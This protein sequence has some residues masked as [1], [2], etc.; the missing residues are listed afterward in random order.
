MMV[1]FEGTVKRVG[2][3]KNFAS[4]FAKTPVYISVQTGRDRTQTFECWVWRRDESLLTDTQQGARL[5]C[6]AQVISSRWQDKYF[7]DLRLVTVRVLEYPPDEDEGTLDFSE[8]DGEPSEA[9]MAATAPMELDDDL[10]F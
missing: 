5:D 7:T 9:A 4:G 6:E 2:E 3:R 8:G 10:P 1:H